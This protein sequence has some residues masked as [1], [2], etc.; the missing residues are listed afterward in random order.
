MFIK[1]TFHLGLACLQLVIS[2]SV[3]VEARRMGKV[4]KTAG[5]GLAVSHKV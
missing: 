5:D 3:L 1:F 4:V 2:V